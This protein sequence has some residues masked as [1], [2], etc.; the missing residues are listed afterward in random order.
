M[1]E[2]LLDLEHIGIQH[3]VLHSELNKCQRDSRYLDPKKTDLLIIQK[4]DNLSIIL[5]QE[6]IHKPLLLQSF[7]KERASLLLVQLNRGL[8]NIFLNFLDRDSM[9]REI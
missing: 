7:Q 8:L 2:I 3:R 5:D 4:Q 6:V 9:L 1:M